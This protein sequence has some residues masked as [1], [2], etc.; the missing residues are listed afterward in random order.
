MRFT[1]TILFLSI[2]CVVKAQDHSICPDVNGAVD[3]PILEK[4]NNS[5]I[6]AYSESK[7]DAVTFPISKITSQEGAA[8]ELTEEGKVINI[9]YGIENTQRATVL[10]V[11]KNYEQALV[12]G[13]FEIVYSAFGKKNISGFYKLQSV[14]KTFGDVKVLTQYQYIKP[15][16]YFRF[17]MSSHNSNINNDDA[18]FVAKGKRDGKIYTVALFIHYNRTSWKGLTDNIFVSAQ[19]V[20]QED[21]ETGQVT[22]AS[23]DE[24]IKNEGK[25]V[26]HNILFD[27]GSDRLKQESFAI[28]ETL[29]GY[30]KSNPTQKYFIVGHTDNVGSLAS[31]QTLSEKRAITVLKTLTTT[32]GIPATQV[33][34]HGVGQLS[35]LAI[36]STDDGRALNRRVEVVLQ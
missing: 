31:N 8:Q 12:N 1:Y 9:I 16:S 21:M 36:N 4:Y 2:F 18:Y 10:E 29:A 5:C 6:V 13:N 23:I 7:F 26:F 3:H 35:P 14:Y 17:S 34:A 30:L 33:S 32:Y 25:E 15:K 11:Q 24:K 28:I 27:F 22:A 19:I 20:E